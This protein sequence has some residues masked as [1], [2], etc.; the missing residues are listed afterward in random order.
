[1][2][3]ETITTAKRKEVIVNIQNE[4]IIIKAPGI[5]FYLISMTEQ[6]AN[7]G[8]EVQLLEPIYQKIAGGDK[9][10]MIELFSLTPKIGMAVIVLIAEMVNKPNEWVRNLDL[11]DAQKIF[12]AV[13][14][15]IDVER[16][17]DFFVQAKH[18]LKKSG[19]T[20][21]IPKEKK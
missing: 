5:G 9:T 1:M 8:R 21:L 3:P 2:R 10:S 11:D 17:K 4:D 16:V 20:I 15:V 14:E 18:Q 6:L 13:L 19:F 7:L 12:T